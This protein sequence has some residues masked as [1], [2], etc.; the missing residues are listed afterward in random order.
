MTTGTATGTAAGEEAGAA[1]APADGSPLERARAHLQHAL[2]VRFEAAASTASAE[3]ALPA[4][5]VVPLGA[6]DVLG[7]GL[8]DPY[9][10]VRPRANVQLTARAVLVGP[11][12]TAAGT[13]CGQCLA[14]RWQRLRS[15]SEREAL[16][17][18]HE[19]RGCADWPLLTD[20]TVDAVWAAYLAVRTGSS[21][22]PPPAP[23]TGSCRRSP[24]STSA[25]S[26]WRRSRCCPNRSAPPASPSARTPPSPPACG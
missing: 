8:P 25:R 4:P 21:P 22:R 20:Y 19:P 10:A 5:L 11:W 15:R 24:G 23:P 3:G 1:V 17:L 9:A 2:N 16:E 12:G 13:A 26:P 14:I 7:F 18:G 6:A